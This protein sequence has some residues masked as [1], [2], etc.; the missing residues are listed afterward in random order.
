[1]RD[2]RNRTDSTMNG[3]AYNTGYIYYFYDSHETLED[4]TVR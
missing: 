1:V 2:I 3:G 4:D